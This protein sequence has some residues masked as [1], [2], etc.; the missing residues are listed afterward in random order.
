MNQKTV[1][2][3]GGTLFGVAAAQYGDPTQWNII[4]AA[5]GLIDPWLVGTVSLIIPPADPS[6]GNGGILGQ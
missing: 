5:N 3:T 6:G 1:T 2:V 4:A